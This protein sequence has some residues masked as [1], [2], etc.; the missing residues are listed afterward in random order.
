MLTL[1]C[2]IIL[3]KLWPHC[4]HQ[5]MPSRE[6]QLFGSGNLQRVPI[7]DLRDN[8]R[9]NIR[10]YVHVVCCRLVLWKLRPH[11]PNV[12]MLAGI[13]QR[14]KTISLQPVLT[15]NVRRSKW[16][17]KLYK[18]R[19]RHVCELWRRYQLSQSLPNGNIRHSH[20]PK[21]PSRRMLQ[22]PEGYIQRFHRPDQQRFLH[23]VPCGDV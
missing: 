23:A 15:W 6:I 22:L 11:R 12:P 2:R 7:R 10:G 8:Y 3:R 1:Y 5:P 17:S 18:L 20:W 21:Q 13:L 4:T 19:Y 16:T 9:W 14:R